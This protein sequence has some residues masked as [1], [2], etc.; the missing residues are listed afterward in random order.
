MSAVSFVRRT[1]GSGCS[2]AGEIKRSELWLSQFEKLKKLTAGSI[3]AP[4]PGHHYDIHLQE[5][6]RN[7]GKLSAYVLFRVVGEY[8]KPPRQCLASGGE[9]GLKIFLVKNAMEHLA[10]IYQREVVNLRGYIEEY[11]DRLELAAHSDQAPPSLILEGF[12]PVRI[13]GLGERV[14][15]GEFAT[16]KP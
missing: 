15:Q 12:T 3:I 6:V 5:N 1:G 4:L 8:P 13:I 11:R 14:G 7:P 9:S 16:E 10:N 2:R